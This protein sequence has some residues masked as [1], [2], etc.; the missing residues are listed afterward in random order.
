[1]SMNNP[2]ICFS[3]RRAPEWFRHTHMPCSQLAVILEQG[4]E[5]FIDIHGM[6]SHPDVHGSKGSQI[7]VYVNEIRVRTFNELEEHT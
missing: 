6:E 1:M 3:E 7:P 4:L 5:E 2:L